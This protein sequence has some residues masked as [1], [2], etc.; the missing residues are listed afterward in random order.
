VSTHYKILSGRPDLVGKVGELV[1]INI[2]GYYNLLVD[3]V[4][5]DFW[6]NQLERVDTDTPPEGK[7]A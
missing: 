2:Q 1:S 5:E 3:E 4:L 6:P 7:A